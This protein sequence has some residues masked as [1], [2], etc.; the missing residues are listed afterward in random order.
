[1]YVIIVSKVVIVVTGT[2]SHSVAQAD[3][4]FVVLLSYPPKS[5]IIG[6]CHNTGLC[7]HLF[8]VHEQGLIKSLVCFYSKKQ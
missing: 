6:M 8:S 5:K 1:M 4:E 2:R 3:L 7:P